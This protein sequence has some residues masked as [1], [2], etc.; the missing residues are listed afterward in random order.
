[1]MCFNLKFRRG[2]KSSLG[3]CMHDLYPWYDEIVFISQIMNFTTKQA[4]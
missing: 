1:M 3:P 2:H 4:I